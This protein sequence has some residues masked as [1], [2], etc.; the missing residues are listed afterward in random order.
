MKSTTTS[1]T[2]GYCRISTA[3]QSIDRQET[4]IK[5]EYPDAIIIKEEYTGT[6]VDGRIKFEKLLRAVKPGDRIIF[7]SV[8]RMSRNA[9]EGIELYKAMYENGV[10]LVFLKEPY[11][12]TET[13]RNATAQQ[14]PMT[15]GD[16]DII[17]RAVNEYLMKLAEDQIKIAFD[18]AEKE[19]TDLQQ[20][21][22]EGIREGKARNARILAGLEDGELRDYGRKAGDK[23]TTK[24][25]LAV[26][27]KIRKHSRDFGGT[28][29]DTDLMKM[30]GVAR[31]TYY[32][33][34][35]EIAEETAKG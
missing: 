27:E 33:Y 31:N 21:T 30:T 17:L 14:V 15:G 22:R 29:S 9:A 4:N 11:I 24:K 19:V 26:K 28:L 35:R 10:E 6:K 25:S 7:D 12:N 3:K 5:R 16:V 32:K 20:R 13:Y 18:Q 1:Q 8:S 23:L 2:F 34:K